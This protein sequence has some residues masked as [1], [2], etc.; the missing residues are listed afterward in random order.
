[1]H[2]QVKYE[3]K[4]DYVAQSVTDYVTQKKTDYVE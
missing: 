4:V 2:P 3:T 1:M